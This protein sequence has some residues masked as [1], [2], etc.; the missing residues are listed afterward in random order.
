MKTE[1]SVNE[2]AENS[3]QRVYPEQVKMWHTLK[4]YPRA[5][6]MLTA[7]AWNLLPRTDRLKDALTEA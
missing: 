4:P 3:T 7:S 5:V 2:H 1:W 6:L